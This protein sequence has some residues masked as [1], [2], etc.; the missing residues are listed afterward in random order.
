MR[1]LIGIGWLSLLPPIVYYSFQNGFVPNTS[2]SEGVFVLRRAAE[3]S[4]QWDCQLHVVQ[5]DLCKAFSRVSHKAVI[6]ALKLQG[7]SLQCVAIS[8]K[9]LL[10][11]TLQLGLGNVESES[12]DLGRGLPEGA[13][14]S[15]KVF[16]L[17][18]EMV[19]RPLLRK[20]R[21]KNCTTRRDALRGI[22]TF[23]RRLPGC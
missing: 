2:A 21:A 16:T 19:L 3:L 6:Q 8:C 12:F 11:T 4:R 10:S 22:S 17:V 18:T 14:E 23:C 5:I 7:A 15:P 9:I 1:K 20:W 13:P